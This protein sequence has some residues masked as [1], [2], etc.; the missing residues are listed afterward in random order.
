VERAG[1]RPRL[2]APGDAIGSIPRYPEGYQVLIS[3]KGSA[4]RWPR[5]RDGVGPGADNMRRPR[6]GLCLVLRFV[7]TVTSHSLRAGAAGAR[8]DPTAWNTSPKLRN[9]VLRDI[10]A[11]SRQRDGNPRNGAHNAAERVPLPRR[12]RMAG[13]AG[14]I[15]HEI[16]TSINTRVPRVYRG[17]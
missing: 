1:G 4:W 17:G 8:A 3:P 9:G 15:A 6:D 2:T 5:P 14:T 11:R 13:W 16:L 7:S 10:K 12:H